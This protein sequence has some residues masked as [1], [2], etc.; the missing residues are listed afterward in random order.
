MQLPAWIIDSRRKLHQFE[1]YATNVYGLPGL[2]CRFSDRRREPTYS[3]F[4]VVNALL[5]AALLRRPS[6]NAAEGDLKQA[7]FQ[8][9][10][11]R[12]PD[13][14]VKAFSAFGGGLNEIHLMAVERSTRAVRPWHTGGYF[15]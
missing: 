4:E 5:H 12:K 1:K 8:K 7:D 10:I 6:I 2:L 3:T 14:G 11:G 9:V 15:D 13:S